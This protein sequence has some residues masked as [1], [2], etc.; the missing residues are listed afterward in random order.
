MN[1]GFVHFYVAA[2]ALGNI[3]GDSSLESA[4][5]VPSGRSGTQAGAGT[6]GPLNPETIMGPAI[7]QHY[8]FGTGFTPTYRHTHT[9]AVH[10]LRE[11]N[12]AF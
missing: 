2:R 11:G 3:P 6:L 12:G 5:N 4:S 8:Q 7:L 1:V 9:S 10:F